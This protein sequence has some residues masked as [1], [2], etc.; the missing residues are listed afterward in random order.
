MSK[1]RCVFWVVL[2]LLGCVPYSAYAACPCSIWSS[3][4]VPA[5]A[6]S[7][8]AGAVELGTK[9]RA[10]QD[11]YITAVRFYKSAN[12][13]G[14]HVGSVWTSTGTRLA[15]ATFTNE[16]SVG[17]QQVSF[18]T[19]VPVTANTTYI[20]S[21]YAPSGH[22]AYGNG[23]FATTGVDNA[24][25]H[26]LGN[27]VDGG[28][29]VYAYGAASAFPNSTYGASNYWVDVVYVPAAALQLPT[30]LSTVP[31]ASAPNVSVSASIVATFAQPMDV[32][33][34][35]AS[36]FVVT[37]SSAGVVAGTVSYNAT[38][39]SLT[40]TPTAALS[41]QTS[42]SARVKGTVRDTFGQAMGTD[43]TWTFT[44]AAAPVATNCPCSIWPATTTPSVID[45]NDASGIEVGVK[46]TVDYGGY[47]TGV[48]FYKSAQNTGTHVGNLWTTD[49]TKLASVTFAGESGSGWQQANFSTPVPVTA[50][51]TYI[52]S[53]YAPSGHYSYSYS[54]FTSSGVDNPPIHALSNSI[55]GGNG[56]YTYGAGSA[57]PGSSYGASNYW[58]DVVYFQNFST[59]APSVSST[60]PANGA[61]N[62]SQGSAISAAFTVPM[63]VTT[64][65]SSN[66]VVK[67]ASNN[68][69]PGT[70]AYN[71]ST[72]TVTFQ[73]SSLLNLQSSYTATVKGTVRNFLGIAL[74]NDYSW[75]FS[76]SRGCPCTI[77]PASSAPSVPDSGEKAG[78]ELGVKFKADSDGYILGLRFYKSSLNTGTHIGNL[79]SAAGTR[80]ATATFSN[81]TPT[82]W[83]QVL[84]NSPVPITADTTYVASYY[85][86]NGHYGFDTNYFA[87][88]G[89]DTVPLHALQSASSGGNG[90]FT[91]AST[92]SFP[93]SSYNASNYWVD[94]IYGQGSTS[95]PP[96]VSGVTPVNGSIGNGLG[97]PISVSFSQP[98]DPASIT[99][100]NITVFDSS[101]SPIPGSVAYDLGSFTMSFQPNPEFAA[102]STYRA[103]VSSAVRN[104][105][106]VAMGAN[107]TWSFA[108]TSTIPPATGPGG[109]ILVIT[110]LTN[111]F[112]QYL[113]EILLAEGLNAFSSQDI[114]GI[115]PSVLANYDVVILGD[116][117]LTPTHVSMLSTWVANGG[118]LIAMHPDP[119]LAGLLGLSSTSNTLSNSYLSVI[120]SSP[121]GQG[122]VGST[123]QFHGPAAIFNLAGANM[124]ARLYS[125]ATTPTN[126]P[127]VTWINSGAGRAAAFTYDLA[128][129]IVYMRQGNPAWVGVQRIPFSDTTCPG[130]D[131]TIVRAAD[132]FF[133]NATF[134]PEPD[135]NDLSKVAVPQA[136]EQQRLLANLIQFMNVSRKPLPRFWYLPKGYKAAVIMTGDDHSIG[137]T[138]GRFDQYI[139]ASPAGCSVADWTCVRATSYVFPNTPIFNYL[140]YASQG[141]EIANH[142]DN[143]TSCTNF[144]YDS[145]DS[146]VT[147]QLAQMAQNYPGLP[148]SKTNRTHCVVWSDWD[149]EPKVLLKH[150]IRLDTSY[151]YWPQQ[152][153]LDRPGMFTGSG[154]PMRYAD[155]TGAP[156]DVYQATTQ[157]PDESLQTFPYTIDTLLDNAIGAN[158][159]YGVFTAN[160]HTDQ[161]DSAGSDAIVTSAQS[162]GVPIISS[163]QMLT[164]LDGRN[165]SAFSSLSWSANRLSFNITNAAGATNIQAM[166]PARSATN[167]VTSIKRDGTT[168]AYTMQ[169]IKGIQYAVFSGTAGSYQVTYSGP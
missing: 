48:R 33:T 109:P 40:F 64:M 106:G 128:R 2:F 66:F 137:G 141:F 149:S 100:A 6:D 85:A 135:W 167:S 67:D 46:F 58:V 80:L 150:G 96:T 116:M 132:M 82:G 37:D 154:M 162:R 105:N 157:M 98:M 23:F 73:P 164:W 138:S 50:G 120:T 156:I 168:I 104:I 161:V 28:N 77:W 95:T 36:N 114:A 11:G 152:W 142:G 3:T 115:T 158:G 51:T 52:V 147:T 83:Q 45:S 79:W 121:P 41:P 72:A 38:S 88:A 59:T 91:Y 44:T 18:T 1:A 13:T 103:V 24:P 54:Y 71:A 65:T 159:Y 9:F 153:I 97:A 144:S 89:V 35:V 19:P 87:N 16:T 43:Y 53:Y 75:S 10:D 148:A 55:S 34:M 69:L 81:E 140:S 139:A 22:Y 8:D 86:P 29:G 56:V 68:V 92:S 160:M 15:S 102:G 151:Y 127:A 165:G 136:D 5:V 32:T 123:M 31:A 93:S 134:D 30:V 78:V 76:T 155:S 113:G 119:Q 62:V 60:S 7:G 118:N 14:T 143:V 169:T 130:C 20:V 12:N 42:Y 131:T 146:A 4:T 39:S 129:S 26:A 166:V 107:Y 27:G 49:G 125:N 122:I 124:V 61:T 47:I 17:W 90:V 84:F 163:L 133:G 63:D 117:R 57:F 99:T 112:T 25:L 94:V 70:V 145:L 101:N 21:Y 126:N 108:T 74:G 111:P 110:S